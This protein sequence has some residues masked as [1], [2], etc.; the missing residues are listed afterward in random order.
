[1]VAQAAA[2][3]AD[4][5]VLPEL[6]GSAY[7]LANAARYAAPLHE[8]LFGEMAALAREHDLYVAGSLLEASAESPRSE[9]EGE[10][11]IYNTCALYGPQ[12]PLGS[13]RK[14]HLIGLMDEDFYLAPGERLTLC[15][16]LP[17]GA[18]G[19]A[20]CYDLRFPEVFRA[21]GVAGARLVL[22]PA[23]WPAPRIAHWRTLLRARAIENQCVI[24][25]CN[26]V[27][28][29]PDNEFPGASALI[30]PSGEV[31]VEGGQ[32]PVLL[33][34]QVNMAAV[35][36]V[37]SFLSVFVDRRPGCYTF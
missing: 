34:A 3:G 10:G 8:G 21:Y 24:A 25:A 26:R 11:Q 23:Q 20:I 17:W 29:D 27:G 9:A 36:E 35:D 32:D 2:Q 15:G 5:V 28:A 13:Y 18:T 22:V 33:V 37:R 7:D 16:G 31:L 4:L 19:L 1:M 14:L 12:G 30:G 6:W